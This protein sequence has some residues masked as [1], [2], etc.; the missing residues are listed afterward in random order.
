LQ[1]FISADEEYSDSNSESAGELRKERFLKM[2]YSWELMKTATEVFVPTDPP[3]SSPPYRRVSDRKENPEYSDRWHLEKAA[4][5]SV[6]TNIKGSYHLDTYAKGQEMPLGLIHLL[7]AAVYFPGQP[8]KTFHYIKSIDFF[9]IKTAP[10]YPAAACALIADLLGGRSWQSLA[11]VL[12]NEGFRN[13]VGAKQDPGIDLLEEGIRDAITVGRS[14]RQKAGYRN[15]DN[16]ISFIT[17][18][19]AQCATDVAHMCTVQE[20]LF[21]PV[22]LIEYADGDLRFLIELGVNYGRDND[23]A[24]SI[25]ATIGGAAMGAGALPQKWKEIVQKA[26][27][28]IDI[29][30][31]AKQLCRVVETR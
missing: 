24:A 30:A 27:S 23:T 18:L 20:M 31:T 22:A 14:Y 6:K 5:V 2:W 19:H 26:N 10:L 29:S 16:T 3:L 1:R 21:V 4:S 9:D 15:K 8:G 28:N 7:P 25:A 11:D 12:L 13:Y 17:A